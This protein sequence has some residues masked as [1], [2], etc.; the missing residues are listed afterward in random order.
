MITYFPRLGIQTRRLNRY[1]DGKLRVAAFAMA[2]L[3]RRS[4]SCSSDSHCV[5]TPE[6]S[7]R[8]ESPRNLPGRSEWVREYLLPTNK[9][10]QPSGTEF[11]LRRNQFPK[12]VRPTLFP[13][14][15]LIMAFR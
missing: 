3:E 12:K 15:D 8:W 9:S 7:K 10:A 2:I 5:S 6:K 4:K 13:G 1:R 14:L 11:F